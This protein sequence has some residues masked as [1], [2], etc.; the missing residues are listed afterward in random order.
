M[1]S[2]AIYA[3]KSNE[4][5]RKSPRI[6]QG[7]DQMIGDLS[8]LE[9]GKYTLGDIRAWLDARGGGL[10]EFASAHID[11]PRLP[12]VAEGLALIADNPALADTFFA[13]PTGK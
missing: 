5:L 12:S 8:R 1:L 2:P 4:L 11:Q 9:G 7:P 6:I 10:A 3:V 13:M